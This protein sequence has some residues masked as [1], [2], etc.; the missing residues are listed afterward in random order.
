MKMV[1]KLQPKLKRTGFYPASAKD[2]RE[3]LA[4]LKGWIDHLIFCDLNVA[5]NSR[6]IV[7][8]LRKEIVSN[9]L[10][11]ASFILGDALSILQWMKPVDIFFVRH[12]ST[13]EGGSHLALLQAARI[14]LVLN[15]IKLGG[16]LV[17][18]KQNGFLWLTR[19]LSG[20][21]PTYPVDNR[22]LYLRVEQPWIEHGLYAVIVD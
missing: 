7:T 17:V 11:E 18:D 12:D 20:K 15:V 4:L 14:R 10:P 9:D 19:M 1:N 13:C 22:V 16:L 2:Y 5:P 6:S 21:S 8:E 3:P